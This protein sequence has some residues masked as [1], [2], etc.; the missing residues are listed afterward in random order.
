[1]SLSGYALSLKIGC[2]NCSVD[3][4]KSARPDGFLDVLSS[5]GLTISNVTATYDSSFLNNLFPGWRFP[6][7]SYKNVR[8]ENISLIDLAP[9][10]VQP[11]IGNAGQA[12]NQGIV[13]KNVHVEINRWAGQ[14]PAPLPAV[15]GQM[16]DVSVDC[17]VKSDGSRIAMSQAGTVAITFTGVPAKLRIGGS[18]VLT[19]TARQANTCSGGGEWS[20][21]L[22]PSGSR[23]LTMST[24]GEHEFTVSCQSANGTSKTV[25]LRILVSPS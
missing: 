25:T 24:A 18:T 14:G 7:N 4:Y 5:D 2:V 20:G 19:W 9:S 3:N 15:S 11:P 13:F 8:F 1:D 6:S 12:S 10:S 23:T 21:P 17:M 22:G 16:N